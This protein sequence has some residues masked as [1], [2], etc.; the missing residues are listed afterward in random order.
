MRP[1]APTAPRPG[2]AWDSGRTWYGAHMG[3]SSQYSVTL[4]ER[5]RVVLPVQ[6]RHQLGLQSG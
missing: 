3:E 5:G 1:T 2:V 4:G 6:L